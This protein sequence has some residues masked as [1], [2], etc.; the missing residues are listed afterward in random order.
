MKR[1]LMVGAGSCQINGILKMKAMGYETVVA[2]YLETSKGKKIA[3]IAVLADAFKTS[4]ILACAIDQKVQ[5]ILTV[6]TDQPV[7]VVTKV[8]EQLNLPTFI[9]SETALWVTDKKHM[10]QRFRAFNIPTVPFAIISEQF[11]A[12]ELEHL[13]PPYVVKPLD[14]QGQRGIYKLN[15]ISEIREQFDKV[16]SYSRQDEIL[17]ES[18]Y[19]NKELTVSGWVVDGVTKIFTITDRVTFSP[20]AHI[21]VCIAHEY[22]SIHLEKYEREIVEITERICKAFNIYE[23]PIYFQYLV[24]NRG[25]M[26]NEI[27]CRLGGA[28]EDVTI[29]LVTGIDVLDLAIEGCHNADYDKSAVKAHAYKVNAPLFST[30]L[31]FCNAG[32]ISQMIPVEDLMKCDFIY[33]AGYNFKVGDIISPIENASQRAGYMIITGEDEATLSEN[34]E[35]AYDRL[36][37]MNEQG[38]NLVIRGKRFY[39]DQM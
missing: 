38:E 21:G 31:F 29:P 19:E 23:G 11:D 25:V 37:I 28:Y 18:Y 39:R 33:Q 24:G 16:L 35:R 22:P 9:S 8:C 2:D 1:L 15:A 4:E 27:A 14:S 20:D 6:G 10:K 7:Y 36:E 12:S 26:V 17:V 13:N 30:Q 34:I 3:D 5:G 32:K